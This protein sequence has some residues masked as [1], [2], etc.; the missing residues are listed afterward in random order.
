VLS[1]RPPA[2]FFGLPHVHVS[3]ITPTSPPG[4]VA[5]AVFDG[6]NRYRRDPEAT[7]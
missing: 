7:A 2:A 1:T 5:R 3:V 4:S 6:L